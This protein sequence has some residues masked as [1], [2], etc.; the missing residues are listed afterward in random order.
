MNSRRCAL[1]FAVV[2]LTAVS[3]TPAAI[4]PS[5]VVNR[6]LVCPSR[7]PEWSSNLTVPGAARVMV[8]DTPNVAVVCR[9]AT[10]GLVL[11]AQLPRLI[12]ELNKPVGSYI[13]L[14]C[15]QGH[16]ALQAWSLFFDYP[17]GTSQLVTLSPNACGIVSNG[18]MS[19]NTGPVLSRLLNLL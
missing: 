7:P 15:P 8:P 12:T 5:L 10:R 6:P 14:G 16:I 18:K 3:C 11:G 19:R 13:G 9:G 4:H 17:S 1:V 2:V